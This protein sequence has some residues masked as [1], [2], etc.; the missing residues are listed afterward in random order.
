MLNVQKYAAQGFRLH[1][2]LLRSARCLLTPSFSA[3]LRTESMPSR[4]ATSAAAV[5]LYCT[6][7]CLAGCTGSPSTGQ[8]DSNS[9]HSAPQ[10]VL[11]SFEDDYGIRYSVTDSSWR[12]LPGP[13]MSVVEWD[14]AAQFVIVQNAAAD[15]ATDAILSPQ[16]TRIDWRPLRGFPPYTWAYCYT[17]YD[18]ET[19]GQARNAD[20]PV[21]ETP[22]T[23]CNGFPFSRMQ[24]MN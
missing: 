19:L 13:A 3:Y 11:G 6:S 20:P 21:R 4:Y 12:Q 7:A 9:Q 5:A 18:A 16:F 1:S 8:R 24:R 2:I 22:R 10:L 14:S 17:V 15:S 23:G